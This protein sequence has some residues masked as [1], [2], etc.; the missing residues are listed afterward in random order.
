MVAGLSR[1]AA[2]M[3]SGHSFG[4]EIQNE[5]PQVFISLLGQKPADLRCCIVF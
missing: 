1:A 2:R 3:A 5:S 4:V